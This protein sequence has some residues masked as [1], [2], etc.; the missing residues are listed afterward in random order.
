LTTGCSL[1][2]H[3]DENKTFDC[4]TIEMKATSRRKRKFQ[5]KEEISIFF[6]KKFPRSLL[7]IFISR[8]EQLK[9]MKGKQLSQADG[10]IF[11]IFLPS[12]SLFLRDSSSKIEPHTHIHTRRVSKR[13]G[14]FL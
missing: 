3:D 5:R 7:L 8:A 9:G 6:N 11:H 10:K 12:L 13:G 4:L 14:K 1:L 2:Q